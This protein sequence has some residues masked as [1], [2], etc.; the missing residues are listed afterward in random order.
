MGGKT[1]E[2]ATADGET[3][4]AT[5]HTAPQRP[6]GAIVIVR[7]QIVDLIREEEAA[8]TAGPPM[9]INL[10]RTVVGV[11]V[12]EATMGDLAGTRTATAV[13]VRLLLRRTVAM[14]AVEAMRPLRRRTI[15]GMAAVE[16]AAAMDRLR[17]SRME[18]TADT[19]VVATMVDAE[20]TAAMGE[21]GPQEAP[22]EDMMITG[23]MDAVRLRL[24]S[25]LT[26]AADGD[27][28]GIDRRVP[29]L[30]C[31]PSFCARY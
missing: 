2:A 7:S 6:M 4:G 25:S 13:M 19:V 17:A 8:I 15:K 21:G 30:D 16:E 24:M 3:V 14:A 9:G 29:A 22:V 10:R 26:G 28:A 23:G 18:G 31:L 12:E 5:R 1:A 20:I 11:G 27:M